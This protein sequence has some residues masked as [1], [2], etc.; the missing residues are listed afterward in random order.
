MADKKEKPE[1]T[2]AEPSSVAPSRKAASEKEESI[3]GSFLGSV[4]FLGGFFK[5]LGKTEVFQ[6]RFKEV[7]E[8][9]KENL[10]RGDQRKLGFEANISVRPLSIRPTARLGEK[11]EKEKPKEKIVLGE[12]YYYK[13]KYHERELTLAV[14]APREDVEMKI[15]GKNLRIKAGDFEKKIELPDYFKNAKKVEYKEGILVLE[16][17]R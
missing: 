5:E 15:Q 1:E 17:T 2:Q 10:S 9:I 3:V 14:K 11:P 7:D 8:Q 6:K 13:Y 16:L 4:P 12:D